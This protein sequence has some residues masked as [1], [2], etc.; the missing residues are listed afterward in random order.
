M[1]L[2]EVANRKSMDF[3]KYLQTSVGLKLFVNRTFLSLSESHFFVAVFVVCSRKVV[4]FFVDQLV[5]STNAGLSPSQPSRIGKTHIS[6]LDL[7]VYSSTMV[8]R[9]PGSSFCLYLLFFCPVPPWAS[10]TFSIIQKVK[11]TLATLA[12]S[13]NAW[14]ACATLRAIWTEVPRWVSA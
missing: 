7:D 10:P 4:V 13:W 11:V 2:F 12:S 5:N 6:L 14:D 8:W 1:H 9:L 3:L